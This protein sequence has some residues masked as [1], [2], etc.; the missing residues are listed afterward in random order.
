MLERFFPRLYADSANHVP[1]DEL[2]AAGVRG[3]VFDID[4]TLAPHDTP[5]PSAGAVALLTRLRGLGFGVCLVSNN[6]PARVAGFADGLGLPCVPR[7]RK[8]LLSGIRKAMSL[9]GTDSA[10]TALIGD[11]VF[12]DV[13]CGNRLGL[14]T[15]LVK[16]MSGRDEWTV[17]LKR[18]PERIVLKIYE[19]RV[20]K[21]ET[22]G[23]R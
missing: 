20:G 1:Y 8:P 10:A 17:R 12:T 16:P 11:Q 6:S 5:Y 7:A 2:K 9:L 4:N 21:N 18:G 15:V 19:K 14:Y 22:L 13:W 3:L 23:Q